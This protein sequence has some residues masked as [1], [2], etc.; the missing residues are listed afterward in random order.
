[1]FG[2]DAPAFKAEDIPDLSGK[3]ILVTGGNSGLGAESVLHLA[4]HK[5]SRIFLAA[6]SEDKANAA[7]EEIKGKLELSSFESIKK[8][9]DTV[10]KSTTRLDILL[11]NAGI[12]AKPPSLTKDGY[13]IQFGTNYMG[14][15]LLTRLLLP[16]LEKTAKEQGNKADV[17][18][19]NVSSLGHGFAPKGGLV[20]EECKTDL[21]Y[22]ST[23]ARYGQSKLANILHAKALAKRYPSIKCVAIHPGRVDTRLM[24]GLDETWSWVKIPMKLLG[25]MVLV[26]P[27]QG[28]LTQ[29]F[30][31]TSKDAKTGSYYVPI[32]KEDEA[33]EYARDEKLADKL[34]DWTEKE[35]D[36]AGY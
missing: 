20:L 35:L 2:F 10:T 31:A 5:P 15:A 26:T 14:H 17:R 29:L 7:I 11:N 21:H 30:A 12:M 22:I 3:V 19:V 18:I 32:A 24:R 8:A 33:S 25:G 13:E 4:K 16:L 28:A 9:A 27:E 23:L 34:W 6:R 36:A 1:M